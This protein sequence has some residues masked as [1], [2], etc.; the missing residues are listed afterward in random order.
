MESVISIEWNILKG[1]LIITLNQVL[2]LRL[3]SICYLQYIY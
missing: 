2:C 3:H 1:L